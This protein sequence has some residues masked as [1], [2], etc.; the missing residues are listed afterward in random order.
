V[1][2][3]LNQGFN[4]T[5]Q[6]VKSESGSTSPRGSPTLRNR[7]TRDVITPKSQ[8]SL[9][10]ESVLQGWKGGKSPKQVSLGT[11]DIKDVST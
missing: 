11:A 3:S 6:S 2:A 5:A 8:C 4:A 10:L 9:Q 1:K 7:V